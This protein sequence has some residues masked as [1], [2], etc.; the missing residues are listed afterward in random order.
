MLAHKLRQGEDATGT[1]LPSSGPLTNLLQGSRPVID[2][3]DDVP[4]GG[5]LAV[6]DNHEVRLP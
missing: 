5:D 2:G 3:R 1:V 6:A 4:V